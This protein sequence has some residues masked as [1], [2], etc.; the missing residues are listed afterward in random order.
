MSKQPGG[1]HKRHLLKTLTWRVIATG[2]TFALAW[3]FTEDIEIAAAIGA[4]E[5]IAK[6][7][8]YYAH[9]RVWYRYINFDRG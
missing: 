2:T 1:A 6:M 7:V 3:L 5:A 4:T 8:L 9:E